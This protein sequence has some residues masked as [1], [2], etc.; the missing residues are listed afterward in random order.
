MGFSHGRRV[1]YVP[2]S[3]DYQPSWPNGTVPGDSLRL[4]NENLTC[5]YH[6]TLRD[7]AYS[8]SSSEPLAQQLHRCSDVV[9]DSC[10]TSSNTD[11]WSLPHLAT[12]RMILSPITIS[13]RSTDLR[14]NQ[15]INKILEWNA[16]LPIPSMLSELMI[17]YLIGF[18]LGVRDDPHSEVIRL[19][20]AYID[21][22]GLFV[23][24]V[25]RYLEAFRAVYTP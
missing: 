13:L 4:T 19:H 22:V 16:N 23:S 10:T 2:C 6:T 9:K 24:Y 21:H 12:Q 18:D 1:W 15:G 17:C 5:P 20:W 3:H 14:R 7:R 11:R 8:R 25:R